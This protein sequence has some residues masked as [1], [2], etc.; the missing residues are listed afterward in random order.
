MRFRLANAVVTLATLTA[1]SGGVEPTP[2]TDTSIATTASTAVAVVPVIEDVIELEGSEALGLAITSQAV[3]AITYQTSTLSRIQPESGTV[4]ASESIGSGAATLLAVGD[5]LWAAGYGT[6]TDSNIYR[7]DPVTGQVTAAIASGEVC[8]DLTAGDGAIWAIDPEGSLLRVDPATNEM[9]DRIGI[10]IDREAHT[11]VVYAGESLWVS[12]D[13]TP[14][15]RVDPNSGSIDEFDVGGGVPFLEDD[16]L[17]WGAAPDSLWAVDPSTGSVAAQIALED[18]IEVISLGVGETEIWTGIR[19][20]GFVGAVLRINRA[21]GEVLDEF[22]E[23][24][25]PA[26]VAFGFDS[27]WITD[28]GSN[29]LYR[30]SPAG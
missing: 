15:L 9:V 30:I 28:S 11:N 12:S 24:E 18:S 27:V 10:S 20:L 29:E 26:R 21:S 23:I 19:R 17:L 2:S 13:T 25:I 5:D 1:C 3:W 8:C 14:L 16:G 6:Q 7:I 4:T 22:R